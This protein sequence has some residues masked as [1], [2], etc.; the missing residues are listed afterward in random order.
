MNNL[1]FRLP[2]SHDDEEEVIMPLG[3]GMVAQLTD[4]G[5]TRPEREPMPYIAITLRLG[6]WEFAT[7][8]KRHDAG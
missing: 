3:L 4:N 7:H 5:P 2:R 6:R 1:A 8:L